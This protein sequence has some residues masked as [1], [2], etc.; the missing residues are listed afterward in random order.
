MVR[1]PSKSIAKTEKK[2]AGF[3]ARFPG[4]FL[5][6]VQSKGP[7]NET[8]FRSPFLDLLSDVF[9]YFFCTGV[10]FLVNRFL[11]RSKATAYWQW[12][13]YKESRVPEGKKI[14]LLNLD[15]TS[16]SFAP[17]MRSGL[18]VA[19]SAHKARSLVKKQ[20]TR[21]N[22]T[23]VAVVRDDR[24]MQEHMPHFVIGCESKITLQQLRELHAASQT[25]VNVWRN[26]KSAWNNNVLMQRIL[27]EISIACSHRADLQPV[28]IIDVA[29]C[30][31]HKNV[32]QKAKALG[33]WLVFVPANITSLVQPLDTHGFASFKAW[34]RR[35]YSDLRS[36]SVDGLVDRLS[37]LQVL[38]SAKL[39]FF[40]KQSWT[41]SFQDTGARLPCLRLTRALQKYV[42]LHAARDAFAQE[43][44]V[45][46][47]SLVWP[48]RRPM[49]YAH[50]ALFG[51]Q[52]PHMPDHAASWSPAVKRAPSLP[53]MSIALASRSNKRACR[54]FP[55]RTTV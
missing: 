54:Q 49:V 14:L 18:I 35:Q 41:K 34:L 16:V 43:P 47:L 27:K 33:I 8:V 39:L 37:W 25:N 2:R 4:C 52:E 55:C 28:L 22:L 10:F 48:R 19:R 5:D 1:R 26:E 45:Q 15:E 31:I 44:D 3:A 53:A 32:M 38:Q 20:D 12:H 40:D 7:V 46:T 6:T 17:E 13:R 50:A 23:Y 9:R 51:T 11:Q 42:G 21:T 29:P 30:H 36:K 24:A